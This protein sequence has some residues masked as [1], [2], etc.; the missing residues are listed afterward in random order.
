MDE[1]SVEPCL[2]CAR[3]S[4]CQGFRS[5]GCGVDSPAVAHCNAYIET[6]GVYIHHLKL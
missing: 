1:T 3:V 5:I 2:P 6:H 4:K